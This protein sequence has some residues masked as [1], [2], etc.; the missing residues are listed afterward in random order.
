MKEVV[1]CVCLYDSAIAARKDCSIVEA[2]YRYMLPRR[3]RVVPIHHRYDI[4]VK[5]V[6]RLRAVSS[7]QYA[8]SR[9]RV[10]QILVRLHRYRKRQILVLYESITPRARPICLVT[11]WLDPPS[12]L[13]T[14]YTTKVREV[15]QVLSVLATRM[16]RLLFHPV[17]LQTHEPWSWAR[18]P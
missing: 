6:D 9:Y 14:T 17:S 2:V 12:S 18:K 11:Y 10:G 4:R 8:H 15:F 1:Q 3:R 16:D 13:C 7:D 5:D